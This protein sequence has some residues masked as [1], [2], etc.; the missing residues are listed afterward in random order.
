MKLFSRG[1]NARDK[2]LARCVEV[3]LKWQNKERHFRSGL[4][5]GLIRTSWRCWEALVELRGARGASAREETGTWPSSSVPSVSRSSTPRWS[6]S[7]D[8][9]KSEPKTSSVRVLL[10]HFHAV[11]SVSQQSLNRF[12]S[13]MIHIWFYKESTPKIRIQ[14]G[15]D[16]SPSFTTRIDVETWKHFDRLFFFLPVCVSKIMKFNIFLKITSL[17]RSRFTTSG[18]ESRNRLTSCLEFSPNLILGLVIRD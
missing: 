15:F 12:D 18:I 8:T 14:S 6:R 3:K 1:A 4:W 10:F 13:A 17:L 2:S 16:S 5:T 11:Q 7:V 9:R